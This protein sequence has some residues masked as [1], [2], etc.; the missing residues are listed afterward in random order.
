MKNKD[1]ELYLHYFYNM[2][3]YDWFS[4]ERLEYELESLKHRKENDPI[5]DIITT[6]NFFRAV[7]GALGCVYFT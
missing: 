3:L 6:I 7:S 1:C 4:A 5:P 2:K